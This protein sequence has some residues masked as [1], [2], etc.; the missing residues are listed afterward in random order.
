MGDMSPLAGSDVLPEGAYVEIER[1]LLTPQQR[2]ANLPADTRAT[3]YVLRLHGFLAAPAA[4]G[5]PARI[6]S[7]I[8]RE[9]TGTLRGAATGYAHTFGPPVPELLR[10][11]LPGA[12]RAESE[13]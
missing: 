2:T 5:G 7:L 1:V 12:D 13:R 11:G 6:R 10:V 8:G 4:P 9:H 3:P